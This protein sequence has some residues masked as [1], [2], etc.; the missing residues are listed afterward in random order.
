MKTAADYA[1]RVFTLDVRSL[2]LMRIAVAASVLVDLATRLV[3]ATDHYSDDGVL[4]REVAGWLA[5]TTVLAISGSPAWVIAVFVVAIVLAVAV[6]V[7]WRT[8]LMTLLLWLVMLSIQHRNP[9]LWD[10]RDA[11][12]SIAL[13]HGVLLPWGRAWSLDARRCGPRADPRYFGVAAAAYVVQIACIYLFA[14]L[15]KD[16]PEWRSQLTAVEHAISLEYWA[17]P[18]ASHVLDHPTVMAALTAG[19]IGFE[20]ALAPLLLW[21]W[22][23]RL[24]RWLAVFGLCALQVGFAMFLW[25]DTF[26]L[27]A[28]A[29]VLGL[30]PWSHRAG[31]P[32]GEPSRWIGRVA[33]VLLGYTVALNVL[34]LAADPPFV[35]RPAE[36]LGLDQRWTMFAPAPTRWDGWFIVQATI[37]GR[38]I[39]LLTGRDVLWTRPASFRE[40]IRTTRELVFMR[41]LL[42]A[43][44]PVRASFA[45]A[46][47]RTSGATSIAVYFVPVYAGELRPPELLVTRECGSEQVE[48]R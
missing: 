21:P 38:A 14:A 39:D 27:I 15:L 34:S 32:P 26:P 13:C 2:A 16:G 28:G 41:R 18:F 19:V 4:P 37:D 6:L 45:A 3:H 12:F 48:Q 20:A 1:R 22:R 46:R 8:R 33:A 25:L 47:C 17:R 36:L 30:V 31:D 9:L 44:E 11:L 5:D 43:S 40:G 10:H 23:P 24:V 42:A 7:G 29:M 35:R